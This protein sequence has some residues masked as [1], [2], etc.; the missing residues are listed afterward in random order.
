[1]KNEMPLNVLC[2]A[3][4]CERYVIL[5]HDTEQDKAV[6]VAAGYADNPDLSFTWYD[7][8]VLANRIRATAKQVEFPADF[9]GP[10]LDRFGRAK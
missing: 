6:A 3:K 5:Y 8:A 4:G 7:A 9:T 2:L 1:M 10:E